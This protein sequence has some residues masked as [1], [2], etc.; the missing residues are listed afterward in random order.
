MQV[1]CD[2]SKL[3]KMETESLRLELDGALPVKE[4]LSCKG[5]TTRKRRVIRG[6]F[7]LSSGT[8]GDTL[9]FLKIFYYLG[10]SFSLLS[11]FNGKMESFP[12]TVKSN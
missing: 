9:F 8:K 12:V 6:A 5:S 7:N 3:P 2:K 11:I 1:F 10:I 4:S